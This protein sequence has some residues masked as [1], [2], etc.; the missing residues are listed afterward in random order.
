MSDRTIRVRLQAEINSYIAGLKQAGTATQQFG[1]DISGVGDKARGDIDRIGNAALVGGAAIAGAFAVAINSTMNFDRQLSELGAVSG[2]TAE[3]MDRLRQSALDAGAATAFSASDAARA[4]TELAKAGVSTAD[5]LGGALTGSLDLAAAGGLDL[6]RAAEVAA[7][8]MTTFGLGG[9]D[10]GSI[11]D[12]LAAGANKS[13][14]DVDQLA[15]ALQQS[16]LVADQFGLTLDDSV[17]VLA[18]FAQAGLNGSDAGTSFKTML[19]RLTPQ[20][21]EAADLMREL[22]IDMFDAAGNFVGIEGAAQELQDAL[23]GLT[24]EQRNT[25]L[26]TIFGSDAVRGATILYEEGAAGIGEW[27]SQVDDAGFASDVAAKRLDNLAGDFEALRG[28]IE[29][30]LIEGGSKGT[31]ALRFLTQ[32]ATDTVTGFTG[33]PDIVQTAGVAFGGLAGAGSLVLA[34]VAKI[35]PQVDQLK[36]SLN[37]MGTAGQF[38]SR[39]LGSIAGTAAAAGAALAVWSAWEGV[40]ESAR[41]A[42]RDWAEEV[43]RDV[44]LTG[45]TYDEM[46]A[47]VDA[48]RSASDDLF[49]SQTANPFDIDF[50]ES[51][52]EGAR[53]LDAMADEIGIVTD[54]AESLGRTFGISAQDATAFITDQMAAGVDIFSGNVSD[55]LVELEGLYGTESQVTT[56]MDNI[57]AAGTDGFGEA[58]D[59]AKDAA[60]AVDA[61]IDA[62]HAAVDPLF[63]LQRAERDASQSR[64]RVGDAQRDLADAR[65]ALEAVRAD[66]EATA[67]D[68]E[69]AERRV[70]EAFVGVLDAQQ[71]VYDSA[72]EVQDAQAMLAQS[73]AT[74]TTTI[75]GAREA[76][77]RLAA[78]GLLTPDEVAAMLGPFDEAIARVQTLDSYSDID[79]IVTAHTQAAQGQVDQLI[80]SVTQLTTGTWTAVIGATLTPQTEQLTTGPWQSIFNKQLGIVGNAGGGW[81]GSSSWGPTDTIP[82]LLSPGEYVLQASAASQFTPSELY[83]MNQGIR[84]AGGGTDPML[85]A[86]LAQIGG[87]SGLTVNATVQALDVATGLRK[88]FRESRREE[89]LQGAGGW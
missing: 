86:A 57:G 3:E 8:A 9:R 26:A 70:E 47:R 83:A 15:Q 62:L 46:T 80:S 65:D 23:S 21:Q 74:G 44:D 60:E 68:V 61:Y 6:A 67:R 28:S 1:R 84:P 17:G 75:D 38:A 35:G 36:E 29:V 73:I 81:A 63:A 37:R 4:Q 66:P 56:A 32:A 41:T 76:L 53:E 7:N 2:A 71:N 27:I 82:T 16:G 58:E 69:R 72:F 34:A 33:L 51:V 85:L 11:A 48:L 87:G 39:H 55:V 52:R 30:A 25:A 54:L 79:L 50:N 20:S 22:G 89:R 45:M 64:A 24:Q 77:E 49:Q 59:A 5:I 78:E 40:L 19:Q 10:V 88:L 14:A 42:A 31:G 13:A 43:R 12:T 18:A